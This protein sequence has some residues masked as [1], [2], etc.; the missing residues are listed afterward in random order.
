S[1]LPWSWRPERLSVEIHPTA[2][3]A[4][5]AELADGVSV[6]AYSLIGPRVRIGP[7]TQVLAHVVIEGR[8]RIGEDCLIRNHANLG[9]PPHHVSY[10]GGP[11]EDLPQE[12]VI[13]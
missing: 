12:L 6:G 9:G 4:K 1:S 7:R 13:G 2:I 11:P 5:G 8:T 10:K 3:V